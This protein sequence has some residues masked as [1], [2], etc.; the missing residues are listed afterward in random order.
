MV[1]LPD[2]G[3]VFDRTFFLPGGVDSDIGIYGAQ[4]NFT[5]SFYQ[6]SSD[7]YP[8]VQNGAKSGS[9]SSYFFPAFRRWING[10]TTPQDPIMMAIYDYC[11]TNSF[12]PDPLTTGVWSFQVDEPGGNGGVCSIDFFYRADG[13]HIVRFYSGSFD[14]WGQL[15]ASTSQED[16]VP[17]RITVNPSNSVTIPVG[18]TLQLAGSILGKGPISS[19]KWRV[20]G[21]SVQEGGLSLTRTNMQPQDS[22]YY[23]L[24][25]SNACGVASS[26][27][28]LIEVQGGSKDTNANLMRLDISGS[29]LLPEFSPSVIKYGASFNSNKLTTTVTPAV[30]ADAQIQVR[31]NGGA[32]QSVVSGAASASLPLNVGSNNISI[33][34]TA[35]DGRTQKQYAI[36]LAN[37][38]PIL[39]PAII[40]TNKVF[41][42]NQFQF[43]VTGTSGALYVVQMTTN[44]TTALWK[45]VET[46]IAPFVFT[47]TDA[48]TFRE[49]F[50]RVVGQ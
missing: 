26:V 27:P 48:T 11:Q 7:I 12:D 20:N 30:A 42:S 49:I 24:T 34:V 22:G 36:A 1:T 47:Q 50:Y 14:G 23:S 3:T 38:A 4:P 18:G 25:A 44:L 43:T 2:L 10:D 6:S 46:N 41:A 29:S 37:G 35:S 5:A 31:I 13:N 40:M 16:R 9:F 33:L 28:F 17:L 15:D 32:P 21:I 8:G 45:S 39:N 19:I